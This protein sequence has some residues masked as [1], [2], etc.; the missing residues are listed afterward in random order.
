MYVVILNRINV[1]QEHVRQLGFRGPEV[2]GFIAFAFDFVLYAVN[3][4]LTIL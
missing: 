3:A 1:A 2:F 4:T